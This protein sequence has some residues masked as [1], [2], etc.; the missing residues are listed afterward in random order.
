MEYRGK[1]YGKVGDTYFPMLEGT[2]YV[3]GLKQ[4]VEE[5]ETEVKNLNLHFVSN[6][7][8]RCEHCQCK[9]TLVRPGKY[10][11]DNPDC[12]DNDC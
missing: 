5:L 9:L 8:A 6:S 12:S 3:D 10:Q 11:C 4:R 1:L 2:D 7:V